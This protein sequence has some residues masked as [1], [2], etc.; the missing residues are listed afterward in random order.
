MENVRKHK[1]IKHVTTEKKILFR[2]TTKLSYNNFFSENLL[3]ID[4]RKWHLIM[5][6]F[7]NIRTK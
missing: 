1:N 2:I 6:R 5:D 4:L 7:I 3:A